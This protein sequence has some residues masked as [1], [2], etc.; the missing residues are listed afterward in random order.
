[1]ETSGL[2]HSIKSS[3]GLD[4]WFWAGLA[5][6]SALVSITAK[7]SRHAGF[8]L[9]GSLLCLAMLFLILDARLAAVIQMI[10]S[11]G[12]AG[13]LLVGRQTFQ[14][15]RQL[16]IEL[17]KNF[18]GML[19]FL[20]TV[21]ITFGIRFLIVNSTTWRSAG[22]SQKNNLSDITLFSAFTALFANYA[23]HMAALALL[24]LVAF[25][26]YRSAR[27]VD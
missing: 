4:F 18:N 21:I 14:T 12:L 1:M 17:P 27:E 25:M 26:A 20:I 9:A 5:I 11:L 19:A 3:P 2:L 15:S 6:I 16:R 23:V 24:G 13:Y 10:I 8:M 7:D 22:E